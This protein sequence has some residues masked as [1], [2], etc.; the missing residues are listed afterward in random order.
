MVRAGWTSFIMCWRSGKDEKEWK[1]KGKEKNGEQ[2]FDELGT[3][4]TRGDQ[5]TASVC[6]RMRMRAHRLSALRTDVRASTSCPPSPI[7]RVQATTGA[8]VGLRGCRR[9]GAPLPVNGLLLL[10]CLQKEGPKR[11]K[12]T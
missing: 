6:A 1:G 11:W 3:D 4:E 8:G 5:S 2:L 9:C 7:R 10:C 12:R